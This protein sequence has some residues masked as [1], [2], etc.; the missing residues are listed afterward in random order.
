MNPARVAAAL[1]ALADAIEDDGEGASAP[2]S[3][4]RLPPVRKPRP[5]VRPAGE[6]DEVSRAK[7]Q[8]L[9]KAHGFVQVKR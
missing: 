6:S 9:L 7:A 5:I 3:S 1:R 2:A 4:P 8:R